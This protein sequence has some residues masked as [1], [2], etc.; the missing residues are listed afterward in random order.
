MIT[1]VLLIPAVYGRAQKFSSISSQID[2]ALHQLIDIWYPRVADTT[3]G[4][5]LPNWSYDWK[6]QEDTLKGIVTQA[7]HT[8]STSKAAR[9][10]P[11]KVG[12]RRIAD[13]GFQFMQNFMWDDQFGGFYEFRDR[14]G[15]THD[16]NGFKNTKRMYGNAFAIY[17]LTAYYELTNNGNALQLAIHTFDWIESHSRDPVYGGYFNQL[18]RDGTPMHLGNASGNGWDSAYAGLKDY[19]SSIHVLEAYTDLY[20]IWPDPR[21]REALED[22]ISMIRNRFIMDR[23]HLHLFYHADWT[24][25]SYID[26]SDTARRIHVYLDHVSFGHD[27]ET[28]YLLHEAQEILEISPDPAFEKIMRHLMDHAIQY[29]WDEEKGG[30]F[31]AAYYYKGDRVPTVIDTRKT[32]WVQAEALNAFLLMASLYP[33]DNQYIHCFEKQWQY[34]QKYLIDHRYG[35]WFETGLDHGRDNWKQHKAHHWKT[36]YHNLR[37]LLNCSHRLASPDFNSP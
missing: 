24:P 19:N 14:T 32:W 37:A 26:S 18:F 30:L 35:G 36:T 22:I 8:W 3:F 13:L 17:A 15:K 20:H 4:G 23:G 34:I 12:L 5:F 27:V 21:L 9:I 11:E 31:E 33:E 28:A 10:F 2:T 1:A 6:K 7:R 29:G 25:V 16:A